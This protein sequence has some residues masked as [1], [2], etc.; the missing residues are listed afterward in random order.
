MDTVRNFMGVF[1]P[2]L[3][4]SNKSIEN[5]KIKKKRRRKSNESQNNLSPEETLSVAKVATKYEYENIEKTDSIKPVNIEPPVIEDAR[6]TDSDRNYAKLEKKIEALESLLRNLVT[7]HTEQT[8]Y[9]GKIV[10]LAHK[11]KPPEVPPRN[12]RKRKNNVPSSDVNTVEISRPMRE[13]NFMDYSTLWICFILF[14]VGLVSILLR[15]YSDGIP[16][17]KAVLPQKDD[18]YKTIL[19][20]FI[21]SYLYSA[22]IISEPTDEDTLYLESFF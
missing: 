3:I 8:D 10:E 17:M 9:I 7:Q 13:S 11:A 16:F 5:V 18:Y 15:S 4:R 2:E 21:Q 20:K 22:N 1:K 6:I 19:P 12:L 14:F